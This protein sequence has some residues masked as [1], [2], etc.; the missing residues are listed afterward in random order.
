MVLI[1]LPLSFVTDVTGNDETERI[2]NGNNNEI[3][4]ENEDSNDARPND[5]G[6]LSLEEISCISDVGK[7]FFIKCTLTL[8]YFKIIT[9]AE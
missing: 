5:M 8:V 4:S 2:G 7:L 1:I 3:E 9:I 6:D